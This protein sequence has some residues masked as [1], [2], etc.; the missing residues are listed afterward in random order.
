M[1]TLGETVLL[2]ILTTA[3]I[4]LIFSIGVFTAKLRAVRLFFIF[5]MLGAAFVSY[6]LAFLSDPGVQ[7]AW[8]TSFHQWFL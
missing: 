4:G 3:A 6:T 1:L 2:T 8:H 5:G 7:E